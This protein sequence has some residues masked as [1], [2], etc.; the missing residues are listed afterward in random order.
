MYLVVVAFVVWIYLAEVSVFQLER[1]RPWFDCGWKYDEDVCF[2]QVETRLQTLQLPKRTNKYM[3]DVFNSLDVTHFDWFSR[4]GGTE[5]RKS[6][7]FFPAEW[8]WTASS[9]SI[10]SKTFFVLR[11]NSSSKARDKV[12]KIGGHVITVFWS[13]P[14]SMTLVQIS[15]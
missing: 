7:A 1:N 12:G 14:F 3:I 6:R 15:T 9:K 5:T 13:V 8:R 11:R 10:G 4:C 2:S